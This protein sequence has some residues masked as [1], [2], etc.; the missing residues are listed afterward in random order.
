MRRLGER[1]GGWIGT[2]L[3]VLAA[4]ALAVGL[5]A[6]TGAAQTVRVLYPA[7]LDME[8][9]AVLA[10]WDLFLDKPYSRGGKAHNQWE[11][12]GLKTAVHIRGTC[13]GCRQDRLL[14]GP[15]NADGHPIC[16]NMRRDP[17][18]LPLRAM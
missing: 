18:R 15:P 4:A 8:K 16:S 9:V 2:S 1:V 5:S 11:I 10:G 12:P 14:P 17:K 3:V 7:G 6:A 13:P